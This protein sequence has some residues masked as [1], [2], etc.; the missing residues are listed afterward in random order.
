MTTKDG[1]NK[2]YIFYLMNDDKEPEV[3]A[4][5]D[6]K[7]LATE[8]E[9][10]R[11][12][13]LFK[14]VKTYLT[15]SELMS[16]YKDYPKGELTVL[17][18][19][20]RDV[21]NLCNSADVLICVTELERMSIINKYDALMYYELPAMAS[22]VRPDIFND[23]IMKALKIIDYDY[24]YNFYNDPEGVNPMY[25]YDYSM[26]GFALFYDLYKNFIVKG[27]E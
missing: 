7:L 22:R 20:T 18:T 26:D 27:S 2:V 24:H 14:K 12:A 16:L 3:Y 15:H 9:K 11:D 10:F 8:F 19:T 17:A 4:Y 5:T 23:E 25:Q 6:D 1:L 13:R 21:N